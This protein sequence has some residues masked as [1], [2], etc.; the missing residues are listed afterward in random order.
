[1]ANANI[2]II[3]TT[4][5]FDEWRVATNAFANDRNQ[6]RNSY[7]VKDEGNFRLA[8]GILY[9]GN[10]STSNAFVVEGNSNISIG[11]MTTTSNLRVLSN[12]TVGNLTILGNQIIT[13]SALLDTDMLL[14]RANSALDGNATIRSRRT[15]TGNAEIKFNNISAVWQVTANAV[16]G[17]STILTMA[18]VENSTFS[19]SLSNVATAAAVG[20][21]YS[22]AISGFNESQSAAN[23]VRV[24][25][26]SGSVLSKANGINFVN[27]ANVTIAVTAGIAG[28]ANVT[29][30]I[31]AGAGAQ[32][33][34]G[35][36]GATGSGSP[37]PQ[38]ATGAGGTGPQG[39]TGSGS[40]GTSGSQG[41]TG[42]GSQGATGTQ[43][44]IGSG[45]TITNDTSSG[46]T[47]YP[48]LTT[49]TSGTLSGVTVSS[50]KLSFVPS[51]GT[52]TATD[53]A[54]TS[55][56]RLKDILKEI[57]GAVG[58]L[59]SLRGVEYHWNT[60]AKSIGVSDDERTQVGLIAQE[61][62]KVLPEAIS[63]H[64]SKTYERDLMGLDYD[65]LIPLLIEGIKEL[66][67]QITELKNK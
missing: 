67:A 8:N 27:S 5:T 66:Q 52:V 51:N 47:H 25:Q 13:G 22:L 42:A 60:M 46:S 15:G 49:A 56:A 23:T 14:L 33:S 64:F 3:N 48:L 54:S 9:L 24:S 40:Q 16:G 19:S 12:A 26:N 35:P 2:A 6:L 20:I 50:T 58:L 61:V 63:T 34:T 10:N 41:V 21:A 38:G 53:F 28:N 11:N 36:Q 62:N 57:D 4:N 31:S 44:T 32:G 37:G 1:M 45:G 55:D 39:T 59:E 30:D 18:N 7:Y 29:F 43:G 17:H 65:K